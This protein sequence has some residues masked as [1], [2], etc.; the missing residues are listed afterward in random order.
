MGPA[1]QVTPAKGHSYAYG[2]TK[3][4][5]MPLLPRPLPVC[6]LTRI[7]RRIQRWRRGP[8]SRGPQRGKRGK[9]SGT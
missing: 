9:G 4:V 6:V 5:P 3:Q 1:P 8:P 2:E 7:S